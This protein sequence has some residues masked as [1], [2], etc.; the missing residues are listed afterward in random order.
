MVIPGC[1]ARLSWNDQLI[2]STFPTFYLLLCFLMHNWSL[3]LIWVWSFR[4][5]CF[6]LAGGIDED[7]VIDSL[8][9]CP[10]SVGREKLLVCCFVLHANQK[11]KVCPRWGILPLT[12]ITIRFIASALLYIRLHLGSSFTTPGDLYVVISREMS[13]EARSCIGVQSQ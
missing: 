13:A 11:S 5:E 8:S 4:L 3:H 12:A 9:F 6:C 7:R 2:S 1:I 10:V